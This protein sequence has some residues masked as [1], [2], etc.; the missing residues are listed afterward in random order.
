LLRNRSKQFGGEPDA[1]LLAKLKPRSVYADK[2]RLFEENLSLKML[3]NHLQQENLRLKTRLN[4]LEREIGR[5]DDLIEDIRSEGRVFNGV[6]KPTHLVTSLKHSVK[7]LRQELQHKEDEVALLKRNLRSTKLG[8]LEVEIQVYMDECTRLRHHL[9]EMLRQREESPMVFGD[10][11]QQYQQSVYMSNV[12]K[13]F[14]V[15]AHNLK[16][17]QEEANH[18]KAKVHDNEKSKRTK[19]AGEVQGLKTELQKLKGQLELLQ[20]QNSKK[21]AEY[22]AA[23]AKQK[24]ATSQAQDHLHKVEGELKERTQEVESLRT[25]VPQSTQDRVLKPERSFTEVAP[26][27]P[28]ERLPPLLHKFFTRMQ[29]VL[30]RKRMLLAVFLSLMDKNNNGYIEV[31][32]LFKGLKH[33]KAG[34]KQDELAEVVRLMG[35]S[36]S[37]SIK[38]VEAW[39]S[40]YRFIDDV[41]SE[42]SEEDT[43]VPGRK[44]EAKVELPVV[45]QPEAVVP[46]QPEETKRPG[47]AQGKPAEGVRRDRPTSAKPAGLKQEG[48]PETQESTLQA[49]KEESKQVKSPE[50]KEVTS[51][52]SAEV[53]KVETPKTK[54]EVLKVEAPRPQPIKPETPKEVEQKQTV[55]PPSVKE[56]PPLIEPPKQQDVKAVYPLK[57]AASAK[58]SSSSSSSSSS[59][60]RGSKKPADD[61]ISEGEVR[62]ILM[63]VALRCQLHRLQ[64]QQ[65]VE[66]AAKAGGKPVLS[67]SDLRALLSA[68]PFA[69]TEPEA[70]KLAKYLM[71]RQ[72]GSSKLA[73]EAPVKELAKALFEALENWVVLA[74][75]DE[76]RYDRHIAQLIAKHQV[77]LKEACRAEDLTDSGVIS[78]NS[79]KETM[80]DLELEFSA[81]ELKYMQLLFYSHNYVLDQVPYKQ[82]IKAYSKMQEEDHA[83]DEES[84]DDEARAAIVRDKLE[85]ISRALIKQK[86]SVAMAFVHSGGLVHP[87][88]LL[89]TL[90]SLGIPDFD[91][92]EFLVFIEGLQCEEEDDLCISLE[93]LEELLAHY[94]VQP[95][96]D[97][98]SSSFSAESGSQGI[99]DELDSESRGSEESTSHIK[100]VSMLE[101]P[102]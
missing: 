51:L 50:K 61:V 53:L 55:V 17:A 23:L 40:K 64:K 39:H 16:T 10:E 81:N 20:E 4:Q 83:S 25:S 88:Q 90:R 68:Q 35:G 19:R 18:W 22:E 6:Q 42:T 79:F 56:I 45:K 14:E 31:S 73:T 92:E 37:I 87:P 62:P 52:K 101:S 7:E 59:D 76:E 2:E 80:N 71:R 46:K 1:Y 13:E 72:E 86:L 66:I 11:E 3:N 95:S 75:E 41:S 96:N 28:M 98:P 47:E 84:L 100:K 99:L 70:T 57:K 29:K 85:V 94:G 34:M 89:E 69:L 9:E 21:L 58:S 12:Q 93:Y 63:H 49:I 5:R 54:P 102:E 30:Q 91:K 77:E 74:E 15:M 8:E 97:L 60:D 67:V 32:E 27:P 48:R 65:V 24:A 78:F 26:P 43:P 82:F 44:V 36:T 38:G 33:N